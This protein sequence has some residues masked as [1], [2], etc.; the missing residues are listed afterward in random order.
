[1]PTVPGRG[2][3]QMSSGQINAGADPSGRPLSSRRLKKE[4]L[5]ADSTSTEASNSAGHITLRD[6]LGTPRSMRVVQRE[7]YEDFNMVSVKWVCTDALPFQI[8]LR[9]GRKS[10]IR[11][12]YVN[13]E[14]VERTKRCA[15]SHYCRAPT[16]LRSG[17]QHAT[18]SLSHGP[19]LAATCLV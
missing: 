13:K 5:K 6:E 1:M 19:L 2:L 15:R 18:T 8:E 7:E 11:K 16:R 9:H 3:G 10:G 14:L 12:I 17:L 4:V